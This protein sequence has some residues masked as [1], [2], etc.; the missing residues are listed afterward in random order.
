M[1][2]YSA[3]HSPMVSKLLPQAYQALLDVPCVPLRLTQPLSSHTL[4][5]IPTEFLSLLEHTKLIA[6]SGLLHPLF[7][8]HSVLLLSTSPHLTLSEYSYL[9]LDTTYS[10][11]FF[12]TH[13]AKQLPLV[14]PISPCTVL[15]YFSIYMFYSKYPPHLYICPKDYEVFS[16]LYFYSNFVQ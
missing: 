5:W 14:Q 11:T 6:F 1:P 7:L 10:E 16:V 4:W 2:Y 3:Q 15:I 9:I 13:N 12:L 8:L